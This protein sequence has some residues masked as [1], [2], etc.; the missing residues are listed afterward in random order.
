MTH[1]FIATTLAGYLNE[2]PTVTES[3]IAYHGSGISFDSFSAD[4]IGSGIGNNGFGYGI[5]LTDSKK[6]AKEWANSLEE[7]SSV[8]IDGVNASDNVNKFMTNA[9]KTHGNKPEILMIIIKSYSKQLLESNEITNTEYDLINAATVLKLIRGRV[10]YEVGIDGHDFIL[11]K[12]PVNDEQLSKILAQSKL[13]KLGKI[14]HDGGQLVINGRIIRSG[15]DLYLSFGL[16]AKETSEFLVRSGI[17]G[18]KYYDTYYNYVVFNPESL[19][20]KKKTH[21]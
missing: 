18:V 4:F 9:V 6:N 8:V 12:S 3:F 17:D 19:N 7:N 20:I 2:Q 10:L 11:W 13:E 14:T 21:F 1:K 15:E 16:S 5:Y